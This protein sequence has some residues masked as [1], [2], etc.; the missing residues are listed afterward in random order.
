VFVVDLL[1]NSPSQWA[2]V[3]VVTDLEQDK[4]CLK[5]FTLLECKF[6]MC[7]G[8]SSDNNQTNMTFQVLGGGN[9]PPRCSGRGC[10]SFPCG[11]DDF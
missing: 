9:D 7:G 8:C 3:V 2:P 4:L 11:I 5:A 10:V 6:C 1:S